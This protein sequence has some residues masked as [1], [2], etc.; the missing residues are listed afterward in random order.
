MDKITIAILCKQK[1]H[2]LPLYLDCIDN[3][4]YP[5]NLISIYIRSNNNTDNTLEILQA[6]VNKHRDEYDEIYEDYED[7]T[8]RVQDL[9]PHDWTPERFSV[10]GNIRQKSL[11][12]AYKKGTN[13]F[14]IDCDN[15]IIP[16]T[17]K[18]LFE[19]KLPIVGPLLTSKN[20]YSNFHEKADA[21]GYFASTA[22]YYDLINRKIQACVSVDVIHCT[23]FI[24][25]D[26]LPEMHY[27]DE[28]SRHEYVIFSDTARKR[29]ILQ[30]LDTRQNY[31][32]TSFA[33]TLEELKL[34]PWY[35]SFSGDGLLV[36][37][38]QAGFGN[39]I[40]ALCSGIAIA[41]RDKRKPYYVWEDASHDRLHNLQHFSAYFE[42]IVPLA[43]PELV[44]SI[45]QVLT[46][47]LPHEGWYW[48]QSGGQ[49]KWSCDNKV[50]TELIFNGS[51]KNV[52]LETSH[53]Q[54]ITDEQA[55]FV[56]TN[57]F[58]PLPR[59]MDILNRMPKIDVGISIRRG[60]LLNY[61]PEAR[62]SMEDIV[63][64]INEK[65]NG[66]TIIIFSD[67]HDFRD[68]VK[69]QL[70]GI[71]LYEHDFSSYID[72]EVPFIEFLI[73]SYKVDRVYG[74]PSSSFAEEAGLFGG[75]RH[76]AKI[77]A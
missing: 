57:Y 36:I 15:F 61:F 49:K 31:G 42:E 1:A 33:D 12:W 62:Q 70:V 51:G 19:T 71:H 56:Y 23:Y 69:D 75:K 47:W 13:Y 5:K 76:Y 77:L 7:V 28:T 53:R 39:R 40:R 8:Q 66:L 59:F 43:T 3:Q 9:S 21:R 64:W 25:W 45:D 4:T 60:D 44:L 34:E 24:R 52:L 55:I 29:K 38:P 11:E 63:R 18:E 16:A 67:D 20:A 26:I 35:Y 65:F 30:F 17:L 54:D 48:C 74:T 37:S 41:L 32:R 14:V 2:C 58:K 10:L 6:W 72:W 50:K 68:E 22:G 73:L 46:E 27:L